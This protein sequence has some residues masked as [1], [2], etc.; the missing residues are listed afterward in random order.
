[1]DPAL[2]SAPELFVGSFSWKF[3]VIPTPIHYGRSH[4]SWFHLCSRHQRWCQFQQ[5]SRFQPC[6]LVAMSVNHMF[7]LH[8]T[9]KSGLS[10]SSHACSSF[11]SGADPTKEPFPAMEPIPEVVPIPAMVPAPAWNRLQLRLLESNGDFD[12]GIRNYRNHNSSK[13][14][15]FTQPWTCWWPQAAQSW[16]P[17]LK[18]LDERKLGMF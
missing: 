16:R 18:E 1:M 6:L 7:V 2:E 12:S 8:T 3:K 11:L 4:R 15:G 17:N 13:L 9:R 14:N 5:W 10:C